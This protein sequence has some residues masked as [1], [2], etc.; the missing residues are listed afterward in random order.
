MNK[1]SEEFHE[2]SVI[3]ENVAA[4]RDKLVDQA[5]K[6]KIKRTVE[7]YHHYVSLGIDT[8]SIIKKLNSVFKSSAS[9]YAGMSAKEEYDLDDDP[10]VAIVVHLNL[11]NRF[12]TG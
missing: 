5:A 6:G 10:T 9:S 8:D 12:Y 11:N 7:T 4:W 1:N 2:Y 3:L